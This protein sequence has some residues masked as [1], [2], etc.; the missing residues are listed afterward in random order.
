[1]LSRIQRGKGA[2]SKLFAPV[3]SALYKFSF[4]VLD[5]EEFAKKL[6]PEM[7]KHNNYASFVRQLNIYG[8][9]K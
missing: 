7:F 1:M 3:S 2:A 9:R 6:I 8:F 5:E 4:I